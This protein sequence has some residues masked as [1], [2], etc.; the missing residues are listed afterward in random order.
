MTL[1]HCCLLEIKIHSVYCQ[2]WLKPQTWYIKIFKNMSKSFITTQACIHS[3]SSK[4][5]ELEFSKKV[6]LVHVCSEHYEHVYAD[7]PQCCTNDQGLG[8]W[9]RE[10]HRKISL[11][12]PCSAL[13]RV[14]IGN[15]SSLLAVTWDS[16]G[17]RVLVCLF[18]FPLELCPSL[19]RLL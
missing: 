6:T 19:F 9:T 8:E 7:W 4:V 11:G 14:E 13:K 16:E 1:T 12:S 3:Q 18:I 5:V 15:I 2:S 10:G 17:D